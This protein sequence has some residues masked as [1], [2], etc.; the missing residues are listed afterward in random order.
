[1]N[2]K[3]S[4]RYLNQPNHFADDEVQIDG[5]TWKHGRSCLGNQGQCPFA[6]EVSAKVIA[7]D[8]TED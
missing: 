7:K 6:D 3:Q 5:E 1:M 2:T 4:G 8:N